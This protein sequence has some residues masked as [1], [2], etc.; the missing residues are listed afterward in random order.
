M[1]YCTNCGAAVSGNFC[2]QCGTPVPGAAG[3]GGEP[4]WQPQ[5]P[6]PAPGAAG[7]SENAA[8]ALSYLLGFI[9]GIVFLA[10]APYNQMRTVRFHAFQSIF[11]SVAVFVIA[12][13]LS[14]A[15][16]IFFVVSF[17]LGTLFSL[18]QGAL[19]LAVFVL[20]LYLM[21]KAFQ[22]EKVVLPVIGPMAEKHA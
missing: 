6:P 4:A 8:A 11:F 21:W 22:G 9:T 12:I 3:P 1:A 19:G 14:I 7:L 16:T 5:T 13:G 17:W 2:S 15:A 20:W 18:L 10:V